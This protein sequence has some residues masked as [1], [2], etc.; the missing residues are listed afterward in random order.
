ML[1]IST[2]GLV[3]TLIQAEASLTN[4]IITTSL[5]GL[6]AFG[7][8]VFS[9]LNMVP[10]NKW[11][12]LAGFLKLSFIQNIWTHGCI[13][14]AVLRWFNKNSFEI[15]HLLSASKKL[16]HVNY[17]E[18]LLLFSCCKDQIVTLYKLWDYCC[19][20]QELVFIF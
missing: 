13:C 8:N 1:V 19:F 11:V 12:W 18:I 5:P 6:A 17:N 14:R 15:S 20:A 10:S 9:V 3:C 16:T 7:E 2:Y 4:Q